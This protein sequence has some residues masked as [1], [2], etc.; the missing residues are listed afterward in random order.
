L[1]NLTIKSGGFLASKLVIPFEKE[2]TLGD[3]EI[4][5]I[6]IQHNMFLQTTKLRIVRI[7]NGIDEENNLHVDN[8]VDMDGTGI[9][10]RGFFKKHVD[11][12]DNELSHSMEH[13]NTP[14]VYILLFD[15]ANA[16]QVDKLLA[17]I[18]ESLNA[19]CQWD[20]ADAHFKVSIVGIQPRGEHTDV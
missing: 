5:R 4:T 11:S 13:T 17:T 2:S 6:I 19:L 12:K 10:I 3:A 14:G 8:Y 18:D 15:E 1:S 16:P 9:T 7:L 20:N